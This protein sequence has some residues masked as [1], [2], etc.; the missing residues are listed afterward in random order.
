[1]ASLTIEP[2][3]L[4]PVAEGERRFCYICQSDKAASDR[5]L[6]YNGYR[7]YVHAFCFMNAGIIEPR[8]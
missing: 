3:C 6:Q 5:Y 2:S 4:L 8:V 1:M 7:I